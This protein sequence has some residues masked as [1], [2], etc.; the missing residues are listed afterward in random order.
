MAKKNLRKFTG[1]NFNK[2]SDQYKSK[3]EAIDKFDIKL[4]QGVC[5]IL[6]LENTGK[7]CLIIIQI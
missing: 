6:D 7:T 5:D 1:F 4:L 3:M 2:T